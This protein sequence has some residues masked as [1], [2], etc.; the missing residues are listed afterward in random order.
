MVKSSLT[1]VLFV[2]LF[3]P[4]NA[5][6]Q[7]LSAISGQAGGY[8]YFAEPAD[9]ENIRGNLDYAT[10]DDNGTSIGSVLSSAFG[11]ISLEL[12]SKNG[13]FVYASGLKYSRVSGKLSMDHLYSFHTPYFFFRFRE[14]G[15]VTEYV[16]LRK[17]IQHSDFIGIPLEVRCFPFDGRRVRFYIKGAAEVNYKIATA[18]EIDFYEPAMSKYKKQVEAELPAVAQVHGVLSLAG[19]IRFGKPDAILFGF[20]FAGPAA[21]I[22]NDAAGI[23]RPTVGT[24]FLFSVL[25]PVNR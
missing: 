18:T 9:I 1:F 19:G 14:S 16:T 22:S 2:A 25:I 24:G 11:G 4:R 3:L 5:E 20:E 7:S 23:V 13:R 10:S 17:V 6:T 15:L 12:T 21:F 8:V